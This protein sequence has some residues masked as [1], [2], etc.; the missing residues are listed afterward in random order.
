MIRFQAMNCDI[1]GE[2]LPAGARI[3]VRA[4]G[5]NEGYGTAEVTWMVL[6][7]PLLQRPLGYQPAV[8]RRRS[9]RCRAWQLGRGRM[10]RHSTGNAAERS[11]P[12]QPA[13]IAPQP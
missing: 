5:F 7:H 12:Q 4:H 11:G 2:T 8:L 3:H 1:L 6:A 9:G 13:E 10:R